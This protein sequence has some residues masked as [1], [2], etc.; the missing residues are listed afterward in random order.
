MAP[1]KVYCLHALCKFLTIQKR[2]ISN[3]KEIDEDVKHRIKADWLK[4]RLATKVLCEQHMPT[5]LKEKIYKTAIRPTMTYG[6]ECWPIKKQH[7]HKMDVAKMRMMR[8]K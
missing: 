7:M 4:W 2:L 6:A 5:R 1:K 8:C 3:D